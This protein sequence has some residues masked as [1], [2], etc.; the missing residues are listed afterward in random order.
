MEV[1][2]LIY[3]FKKDEQCTRL[4]TSFAQPSFLELH[5]MHRI[6]AAHSKFIAWLLQNE[7]LNTDKVCSPILRLLDI[8]VFRQQQQRVELNEPTK[9]A[10]L[11]LKSG[12]FSLRDVK[13]DE[14]V[15]YKDSDNSHRI[16][17]VIICTLNIGGEDKPVHIFLENKVCASETFNKKAN[18]GQTS[19]YYETYNDYSKIQFF[20]FLSPATEIQLKTNLQK[21]RDCEYFIGI[22]YQD[23]LDH[24]LIH[25]SSNPNIAVQSRILI[26]QYCRALGWDSNGEGFIMAQPSAQKNDLNLVWQNHNNLIRLIIKALI[27]RRK[28]NMSSQSTKKYDEL[29]EKIINET[30]S[31]DHVSLL[32]E[33]WNSEGIS[34]FIRSV[35]D[36]IEDEDT[37]KV[38]I[39]CL[40]LLQKDYSKFKIGTDEDNLNEE[41]K[42][43]LAKTIVELYIQQYKP[44]TYDDL[45]KAFAGIREPFIVQNAPSKCHELKDGN[46][47]YAYIPMDIWNDD[48]NWK[49]FIDECKKDPDKSSNERWDIIK[50]YINE[51]SKN[52]N[53]IDALRKKIKTE[54]LAKILIR[55]KDDSKIWDAIDFNDAKVYV[56]NYCWGDGSPCFKKLLKKIDTLKGDKI[57][58]IPAE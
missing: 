11:K 1:E 51:I 36:T 29:S 16:D 53:S 39:N 6:E 23:I 3:N 46:K 14:E 56:P 26:E 9:N 41:N 47:T 49:M 57:I 52:L 45:C 37:K 2:N 17:L 15:S 12:A 5:G 8:I 33:F 18:A 10:L 24:I 55:S 54:G 42:K 13:V 28:G 35:I 27:I 22:N 32:Y 30:I 4:R 44:R 20:V 21:L 50:K 58:F 48:N 34:C 7:E 19:G 31:N 40:T 38:L 43:T 25:L